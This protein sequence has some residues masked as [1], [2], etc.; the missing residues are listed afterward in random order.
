M[1]KTQILGANETTILSSS[2]TLVFSND[3]ATKVLSNGYQ[4]ITRIMGVE[5]Y[6]PVEL[7]V[8]SEI[9]GY[10]II[11]V[12]AENTG[13]ATILHAKK[14]AS[15]YALKIYHKGKRPKSDIISALARIRCINVIHVVE[16]FDYS[17]RICE[18]LPFYSA[19]DLLQHLPIDYEKIERVIVPGINNALKALHESLI[20]HRD[21]KPSNIFFD[22]DFSSVVV[23]DFGI[24]SVLK[25]DVSVR[26]TNLSRTLGYSAPETYTG[27]VSRESDYYSFGI[28]LLHILLGTDPFAGMSDASIL[29]QAIN[30][31]IEIPAT[32]PQR[33]RQLIQG[34][35]IKD[36]NNRW[37]YSQVSD[38]IAGKNPEIKE[39]TIGAKAVKPYRFD[40]VPYYDL[41]S[42]SMAFANDW[43]E[44]KKHLYRGLIEKSVVQYGEDYASK[45]MDLKSM[46]SQDEAV[47]ELIYTLN[48]GAPLCYKGRVFNDISSLGMEM[49]ASGDDFQDDIIELLKNGCFLRFLKKN[50]FDSYLVNAIEDCSR[51]IQKGEQF[52]YYAVMFL[53]N[54]QLGYAYNGY[55]FNSLEDFV[56]Y[57]EQQQ[58]YSFGMIMKDV[59]DDPKFPMWVYAQGYFEQVTEWL[60]IY[61]EVKW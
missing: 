15:E 48:P 34:L 3:S 28:T 5:G 32:I 23:G 10:Q 40:G 6:I 55:L 2:Q 24:S 20:V 35:T 41:E 54:R 11:S 51:R 30:K 27:F 56:Q 33:L 61:K 49:F 43:E 25:S 19:G 36:R 18:V 12:I 22:D 42:L 38:W 53:V 31:K 60:D 4:N 13:E 44:A 14:N 17:E 9:N 59:L 50:G 8:G 29:Y 47:F 16:S 39:T 1:E 58:E 57:A 52:Y 7:S 26:V 45:C 46:K 21:I 37:G